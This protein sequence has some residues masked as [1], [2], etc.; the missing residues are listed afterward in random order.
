MNQNKSSYKTRSVPPK[1][2]CLTHSQKIGDYVCE[3]CHVFYCDECLKERNLFVMKCAFCDTICTNLKKANYVRANRK[4]VSVGLEAV[5]LKSAFPVKEYSFYVLAVCFGGLYLSNTN[6]F[7]LTFVLLSGILI[8]RIG[9]I[10]E[11]KPFSNW[12]DFEFENWLNLAK[13]TALAILIFTICLAPALI[14]ARLMIAGMP[15]LQAALKAD[16]PVSEIEYVSE[17]IK[18]E[19]SL[20]FTFSWESFE[21]EEKNKAREAQQQADKYKPQSNYQNCTTGGGV[22]WDAPNYPSFKREVNC[23]EPNNYAAPS[24]AERQMVDESRFAE[25]KTNFWWTKIFAGLFMVALFWGIFNIPLGFA[26][27][28][29]SESFADGLNILKWRKL[30]KNLTEDYGRVFFYWICFLLLFAATI[31]I[32]ISLRNGGLFDFVPKKQSGGYFVLQ[33]FLTVI[34]FY[35]LYVLATMLGKML[36]KNRFAVST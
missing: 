20:L 14:S 18:A 2:F 22:E 6:I 12:F 7:L 11:N 21:K 16:K 23:S 3:Q 27:S 15:T 25:L 8:H 32:E 10:F 13:S 17:D 24:E 34:R 30:S 36:Y 29:V 19:I 9:L 4:T 28:A 5:E 35:L 33:F 26:N 31:Y 1:G